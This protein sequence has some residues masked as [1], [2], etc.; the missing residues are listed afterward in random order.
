MRQVR[1]VALDVLQRRNQMYDDVCR[2][3]ARCQGQR[4]SLPYRESHT[5]ATFTNNN[6]IV[7]AQVPDGDRGGKLKSYLAYDPEAGRWSMFGC[8]VR[9]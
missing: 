9:L 4:C 1:G 2:E 5:P 7:D 3:I 8:R 6:N